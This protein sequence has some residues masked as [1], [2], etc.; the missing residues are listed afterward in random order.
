M[1]ESYTTNAP[2]NKIDNKS[3]SA[4]D[5]RN[6]AYISVVVPFYNAGETIE[7]CIT[8][9][10]G[11]KYPAD[12]YEIIMVD[13]NSTDN[14]SEIIKKHPRIKLLFEEKKGSYA[15]RNRGVS[16]SK[17]EIIAFTDSDCVPS[18]DWLVII[19]RAFQDPGVGVLQG[20]RL[21]NTRSLGLLLLQEYESE[22][23][24]FTFSG[25][26]P[27]L[28]YGYTN[29]MAVR[30][31]VFDRCGPFLEVLRGADSIFVNRVI[32]EYSPGIVRYAPEAV[33][34]HSEI[35]GLTDYQRKRF[36]YGRSLEL[37]YPIRKKSHRNM[38]LSERFEI[39]RAT[40]KRNNYSIPTSIYLFILVLFGMVCFMSGRLS[41]RIVKPVKKLGETMRK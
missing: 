2:V 31:E 7:N 9:L 10:L 22:R 6:A 15:A 25:R 17:G 13:N 38:T 3:V 30:R 36:L 4:G 14:A 41:V 19:S 37:N 34:R 27:G 16:E 32:D 26:L 40:N 24:V 39:I 18:P 1:Q 33:I 20:R 12:D 21:Y 5:V 29:N 11:Q 35:T 8:A 28:Y 23:A